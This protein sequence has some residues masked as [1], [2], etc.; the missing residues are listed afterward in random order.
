M[1]QEGFGLLEGGAVAA[2]VGD[3]FEK[4]GAETLKVNAQALALREKKPCDK[5][6]KWKRVRT[7]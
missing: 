5:F 6:G 3:L 7:R 4:S 1:E 2:G